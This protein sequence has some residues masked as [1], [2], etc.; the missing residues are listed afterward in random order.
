IFNIQ[1]DGFSNSADYTDFTIGEGCVFAWTGE[2]GLV[3][4]SSNN[5]TLDINGAADN[6]IL[7]RGTSQSDVDEE[8]NTV[9]SSSNFT[10][11]RMAYLDMIDVGGEIDLGPSQGPEVMEYCRFAFN[12]VTNDDADG[13]DTGLRY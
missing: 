5:A 13:T 7:V 12:D 11:S 6:R 3:V 1:L 10:W 4:S 2:H 8:G 9:V